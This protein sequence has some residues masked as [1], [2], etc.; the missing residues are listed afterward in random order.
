MELGKG[1]VEPRAR[2]RRKRRRET[3]PNG[4]DEPADTTK[5]LE[6]SRT[7]I[8]DAAGIGGGL[9]LSYIFVLFY[10]FVAA[11]GVTHR[12]LLFESPVKLPFLNVDLPL[13]SFFSLGP[14]LLLIV[15]AYVLLHLVLLAGKVGHFNAELEVQISE[16]D[17]K[18]GKRRQLPSNIFVQLLAGP[19]EVRAGVIGFILRLI[20]WISLAIGPLVLLVYF[21]FK[22]LPYHNA[23]ITWWQRLVVVT[24]LVLL[25]IL[26]PSVA[27][28]ETTRL[29]SRVRRGK[30]AVLA[31]ASCS[32][33]LLVFTVATFPGEWLD[34]NLWSVRII[35]VEWPP[36]K[37]QSVPGSLPNTS[38]PRWARWTS[39]HELLSRVA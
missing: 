32:L 33:F 24:D 3:E 15:H 11:A 34:E 30:V 12:D 22:F 29:R 23:S 6:A 20:A 36:W 25:W 9:W 5:D 1:V 28:G 39:V 35:P 27:R 18:E 10:L 7:A 19:K 38:L 8:G 4:T 17:E 13:T 31:M 2:L 37:S 16:D 14:G 26:W 21:Q